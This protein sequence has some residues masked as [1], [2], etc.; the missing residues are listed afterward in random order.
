[1]LSDQRMGI[2]LPLGLHMW[3]RRHQ[4]IL[5]WQLLMLPPR[6]YSMDHFSF[7]SN[8]KMLTVFVDP[9]CKATGALG[10]G[11]PVAALSLSSQRLLGTLIWVMLKQSGWPCV[12]VLRH[13]IVSSKRAQGREAATL[14]VSCPDACKSGQGIWPC[15]SPWILQPNKTLPAASAWDLRLRMQR[16]PQTLSI[17]KRQP[18]TEKVGWTNTNKRYY[19]T[20]LHLLHFYLPLLNYENYELWE[21]WIMRITMIQI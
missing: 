11:L 17:A 21:L 14:Q 9:R 1:M 6:D 13:T 10:S 5:L 2:V 20:L 4:I 3:P 19:K 16:V 18:A 15:D 8:L 7:C 12:R